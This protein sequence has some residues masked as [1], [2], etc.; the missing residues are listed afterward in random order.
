MKKKYRQINNDYYFTVEGET[1]VLYFEHLQ[2][3]LNKSGKTHNR[4]S[5][6]AKK[7]TNPL[8]FAKSKVFAYT[9][10]VT[11]V[12]DRES[13]SDIHKTKFSNTL[14]AMREVENNRSDIRYKL[15]YSNFTFELWIVL[16]KIDCN[17]HKSIRTQYLE[18]I[19]R[20]YNKNFSKLDEFKRACN[21]KDILKQIELQDVIDAIQRAKVI[22]KNNAVNYK[23]KYEEN[24]M[25]YEE[26][27]SLTVWE[28]IE[29]MLYECG[30][31]IK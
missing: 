27:P 9:T 8:S 13:E 2:N 23:P 18:D 21:L 11:H 30:V 6:K 25:Y 20:A 4:I 5:I 10:D 29:T 1:E 28:S 12:F 14:K 24:Y 31:K 15:G 17:G 3:L 16:H 26:N 19:N 7:E 22:M